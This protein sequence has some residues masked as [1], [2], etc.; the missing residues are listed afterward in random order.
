MRDERV[1]TGPCDVDHFYLDEAGRVRLFRHSVGIKSRGL[2]VALL[3]FLY[4][5]VEYRG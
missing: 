5:V 4:L 1:L 3:T 2:P